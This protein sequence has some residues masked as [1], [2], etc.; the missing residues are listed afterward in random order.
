MPN[1]PGTRRGTCRRLSGNA[2]DQERK[3]YEET[4]VPGYAVYGGHDG[5][6]NCRFRADGSLRGPGLRRGL[7]RHM[8]DRRARANSGAT[9]DSSPCY[10]AAPQHRRAGSPA[11]S[12]R[13]AP[14]DRPHRGEVGATLLRATRY[15]ERGAYTSPLYVKGIKKGASSSSDQ[16]I[17]TSYLSSRVVMRSILRPSSGI[18]KGWEVG[19]RESRA[20]K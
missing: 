16:N 15:R 6:R 14:G 12:S 4:T 11:T 19:A 13:S 2:S 3:L 8:R 17:S 7:P 9:A 20:L 10:A 5:V 1:I 18:G